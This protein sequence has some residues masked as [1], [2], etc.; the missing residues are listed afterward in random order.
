MRSETLWYFSMCFASTL[1][2]LPNLIVKCPNACSEDVQANLSFATP[3]I[4]SSGGEG[5]PMSGRHELSVPADC[6]HVFAK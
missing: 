4:A 5:S 1:V 2:V 3:I 6:T